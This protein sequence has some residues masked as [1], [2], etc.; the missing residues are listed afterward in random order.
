[1]HKDSEAARISL[2]RGT[3]NEVSHRREA[4]D[5][6]MGKRDRAGVLTPGYNALIDPGQPVKQVLPI[7]DVGQQLLS[8]FAQHDCWNP[9]P[10]GC[11]D[12]ER[13]TSAVE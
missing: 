10:I 1:M 9:W 8:C 12:N 13:N 6:G 11:F 5:G 3:P 2:S 4:S 7:K